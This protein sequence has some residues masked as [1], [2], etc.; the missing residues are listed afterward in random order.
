MFKTSK[1]RYS[2]R[3]SFWDG[4]FAMVQFGIVDQFMTPL[5]LFLGAQ[6]IAIGALSFVSNALVAMVQVASADIT[7]RLKSRKKLLTFTVFMASMLWVPTYFVPF[8]FDDHRVAIFIFLFAITACFNL[9]ARPAWSS[10]MSEY[11]P[12]SKR[13]QYFGQRGTWL[14]LVYSLSVFAAGIFLN[15][16]DSISLFWAFGILIITAAVCRFISWIFLTQMYEPRW[17]F[18]ASDYFSFKNFISAFFRSNF[19]RFSVFAAFLLFGVNL[20]SPFFAVYILEELKFGYL[21]YTFLIGA[22]V[23]TSLIAQQ[24]WGHFADK[25]GNM[26]MV[27]LTALVLSILPLLWLF[28]ANF[29]YLTLVQL[30]AGFIWAGFNLTSVNFIYDV[31]IPG[32]RERCISYYTFL[33]GLGI[34]IGALLG[35]ILLRFL[36]PFLGSVFFTLF[37]ISTAVRLISAFCLKTNIKEVRPALTIGVKEL[38]LELSMLG[39]MLNKAKK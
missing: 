23:F 36:P 7:H 1:V 38:L 30:S 8:L 5:A 11:I 3:V 24:Y 18:Q 9:V 20:A 39:F 21:R 13:G 10:L 2:L 33:S 12:R 29:Y 31:A 26:K 22:A 28:S 35:G 14:G 32:K 15:Y 19:A 25:Y 37:I 27:K 17:H 6:S 34:G 16:Y 4:F